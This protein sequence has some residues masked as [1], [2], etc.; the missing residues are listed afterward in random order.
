[1]PPRGHNALHWNDDGL[2]NRLENLRW[3][4]P[5]ENH[6][7]SIFNRNPDNVYS[8]DDPIEQWRLECIEWAM[9]QYPELQED[10]IF[11]LL[12]NGTHSL[13]LPP[14]SNGALCDLGRTIHNCGPSGHLS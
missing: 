4:T 2:D 13:T 3:G 6:L 10:E 7:D 14:M 9:D 11:H 8:T 5:S 1:L 12:Q